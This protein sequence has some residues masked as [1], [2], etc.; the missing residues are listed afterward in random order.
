MAFMF[1][2]Y[3]S[4]L[5]FESPPF[6]FLMTYVTHSA[7]WVLKP[8]E[9]GGFSWLLN[10]EYDIGQGQTAELGYDT[11]WIAK[12]GIPGGSFESTGCS[13]TSIAVTATDTS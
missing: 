3:P 13:S 11:C 5:D 10:Y 2:N 7:F 12:I 4:F 8:L 1:L 6:A 9:F